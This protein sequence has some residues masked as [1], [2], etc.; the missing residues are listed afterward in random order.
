MRP[1]RTLATLPVKPYPAEA[2][3]PFPPPPV[4]RAAYSEVPAPTNTPVCDSRSAAGS[5]PASSSASHDASSTRRCCGSIATA[6]RG[7]IPKKPASK[8]AA[9]VRK[10]PPAWCVPSD[11][12]AKTASASQPRSAGNGTMPSRPSAMSRQNASGEPAPPG[13]RQAMPTIAIGSSATAAAWT[14]TVRAPLPAPSPA[15]SRSSPATA[16]G[17][18]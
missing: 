11:T 8:Y 10:P 16:S 1:D 7:E 18:G 12:E 4:S 5:K 17:V 3:W 6:S 9:S 14:T 13:K 2:A 15:R